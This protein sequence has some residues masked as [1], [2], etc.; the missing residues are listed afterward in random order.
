[1]LHEILLCLSGQ[2][3][4]LFNSQSEESLVAEDAFP[5]V[6]P[7]EKALLSSLAHL[8]RLH[9]KLRQHTGLISASHGSVI[10]RA[11][12]TAISAQHLGQFQKR[13]LEVEK[14]ILVEDSG[15]VG[16]YGIVP[17]STIVG[18]FTPWTRRLEWLW[19][20]VMHMQFADTKGA[21]SPCSGAALIDHLRAELQTGYADVREIALHL[22][23]TAETAWVRQLSTWLL[24]GNL[25][26][27]G[28]SDFFI[29]ETNTIGD[30]QPSNGTSFEMH[31]KLL[32]QF[33]L[34]QTASSILFIGKTLNFIRIKRGTSGTN[35][36]TGLS[37]TPV[38]LREDHIK[39]LAALRSPITP[40]MISA[41]VVSIRLSLSQSTLSTLLP[42]SKVLETLSVLHDFLLLGR[43]EFATALVSHAD[44][45]LYEKRQRTATSRYKSNAP[46][47]IGGPSIKENDVV[48][49]LAQA[50]SE[51]YSLQ[52]EEDLADDELELARMLLNLTINE[53]TGDG[54]EV[55][56][57]FTTEAYPGL[58][59]S[60]ISFDD[61]LF[62]IATNLSMHINSPLDLF[63]SASDMSVY[64]RIHS[65]LLGIRRAH[66]HLGDLWK[67]T[68]LRRC[69]PSPWGPPRS[70]TTYGQNRL[71]ESRQRDNTRL[72]QMRAVWATSNGS[73][74][75][76]SEIG[77]YFQGEIINESWRHFRE[78]IMCGNHQSTYATGSRPGTASSSKSRQ[79]NTP[80]ASHPAPG[81]GSIGGT[82]GFRRHDPETIAA[83]HRRYLYTLVEALFLTD[84]PFMEAL[85]SLLT[86]IEHFIAL[87]VR[88][89]DIQ[90][91]MDLETDEGVID[92]LV[93]YA[94]EERDLWQAL[95]AARADVEGGIRG[96]VLRLRDIDD[97]RS[98]EGRQLF[99]I[100]NDKGDDWSYQS[101]GAETGFRHYIPRKAA[102]VDRLLMKLEFG[103]VN[104]SIGPGSV[105]VG[106]IGGIA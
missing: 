21:G 4:T 24:Y 76:L 48:A 44:R 55:S 87:I 62:P 86:S 37:T 94:G 71:A 12:S 104:G 64:S 2:P 1:M 31:P 91:N 26:I 53:R 46:A 99:D 103:N 11:V 50:L 7:P 61:L 5:L 42:T 66:F 93:D 67:H 101:M 51:L 72:R 75:V 25:P 15:Y 80:A 83:A 49:T 65:F 40:T 102:G 56:S 70:N 41:V 57:H 69:Y 92:S 18:E 9:A 82:S 20:I 85:R 105:G 28:K 43:G 34:P 95:D 52:N 27:L 29:H 106:A 84:V 33:V 16:G 73:L 54:G 89:E 79:I 17:L 63:I 45:R 3:S 32:P 6:S 96:V 60:N 38:T 74:F 58:R 90:R 10:C 39:H 8:S 81:S 19:Q 23:S 97:S 77:S 14:A 13:I 68:S 30:S 35:K 88:L 47:E 78:W 59:L 98:A 22:V 100:V 36:D